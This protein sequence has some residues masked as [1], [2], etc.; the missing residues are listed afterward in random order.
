MKLWYAESVEL[1]EAV[2]L[3]AGAMGRGATGRE[4][5]GILRLNLTEEGTSIGPYDS[6]SDSW[7]LDVVVD[8]V[9]DAEG[10][11]EAV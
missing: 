1:E 10:A 8:D 5:V 2:E 6:G 7:S 9:D 11:A 4:S 3:E